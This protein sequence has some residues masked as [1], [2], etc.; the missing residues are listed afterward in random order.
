MSNYINNDGID[1][2]FQ[3]VIRLANES[4]RKFEDANKKVAKYMSNKVK[5]YCNSLNL[6]NMVDKSF[7]KNITEDKCYKLQQVLVHL[8]ELSNSWDEKLKSCDSLTQDFSNYHSKPISTAKRGRPSLDLNI[9]QVMLLREYHFDWSPIATILGV[10]RTTLWRKLHGTSFELKYSDISNEVLDKEIADLKKIHPLAGEKMIVGFLRA[11]DLFIQR[12]RVRDSIHRVDPINTINRWLRKNPRWVYSVPGPNSLWH[13]D[14]L[15]KLIHW[16]IVIHACIDGFSRLVTSLLCATNN[17]AESALKGFLQGVSTF[18]LPARVRGD[19]GGENVDILRFMREQ[20]G[21]G[22]A[23]IQGPSVHNQRIERLHYDTTHCVL[24]HF[25]DI[26]KYLE[27]NEIMKRDD[28]VDLFAIQFVF[29]PRIQKSLNEFQEAWNH[30]QLSTERNKSPYQLW[31]MGMMDKSKIHQ[32]GVRAFHSSCF[33][34]VGLFGVDPS[35]AM[36]IMPYDE[37][38]VEVHDIH[39]ERIQSVENIISNEFDPLYD[40]KNFGIDLYLKVKI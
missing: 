24:S 40:D 28:V 35:P 22:G 10:H 13:N 21:C 25:I 20:Q 12:S 29:V 9:D 5:S 16:G 23:Y 15:H 27:E 31:I 3:H 36:N 6:L 30:H 2:I 1:E 7:K 38:L 17:Y 39:F 18:G 14:G 33:D 4:D 34:D 26:F 8:S 32:Q 19:K 11:K 37:S